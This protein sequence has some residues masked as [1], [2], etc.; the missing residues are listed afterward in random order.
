MLHPDLVCSDID[1]SICHPLSVWTL[2]KITRG[3]KVLIIWWYEWERVQRVSEQDKDPLGC[4]LHALVSVACVYPERRSWMRSERYLSSGG[5]PYLHCW[6]VTRPWQSP[7]R[8]FPLQ[9]S[10]LTRTISQWETSQPLR[11][12]KQPSLTLVSAQT[13]SSKSPAGRNR[14]LMGWPH[15]ANL[16]APILEV[17]SHLWNPWCLVF[18]WTSGLEFSVVILLLYFPWWGCKD[19]VSASP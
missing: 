8:Y 6:A 19:L 7:E 1:C 3:C 12:E 14:L 16:L 18:T 4:S 5:P 17:C 10:T 11:G 13:R 2:W 15:S 9:T